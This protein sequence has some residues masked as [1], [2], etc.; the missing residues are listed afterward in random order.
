MSTVSI[1]LRSIQRNA[2]HLQPYTRHIGKLKVSE[3]YLRWFSCHCCLYVSIMVTK[4]CEIIGRKL[5]LRI[6]S[7]SILLL[8]YRWLSSEASEMC[9]WDHACVLANQ[10]LPIVRER[11]FAFSLRVLYINNA[12]R[13]SIFPVCCCQERSRDRGHNSICCIINLRLP[14][15]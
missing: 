6:V 10:K 11:I 2:L 13:Q 12:R 5:L 14:T 15:Y 4:E 7:Y 8:V 9:G 3:T 1:A